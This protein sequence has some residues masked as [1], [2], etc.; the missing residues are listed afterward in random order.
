MSKES[1]SIP[2]PVYHAP[3]T[4]FDYETM[5]KIAEESTIETAS[6]DQLKRSSKFFKPRYKSVNHLHDHE[7]NVINSPL[8]IIAER[9]Y[10]LYDHTKHT[11]AALNKKIFKRDKKIFGKVKDGAIVGKITFAQREDHLKPVHH[12]HLEL[13]GRTWLGG[14]S[15]G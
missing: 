2:T 1:K 10:K 12:I 4:D 13:W 5:F 15:F 6:E 11:L 7:H 14:F 9:F 8:A 3:P